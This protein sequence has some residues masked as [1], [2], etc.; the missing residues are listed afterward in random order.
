MVLK[1]STRPLSHVEQ[2]LYLYLESMDKNT[3]KVSEIDI[4]KVGIT[5]SYLYVLVDRL[6]KKGW[7]TRVG[8]GVYLRLPASTAMAGKVYLKIRW[9]SR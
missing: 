8:K 6:E 9:R 3:F 7:L 2:R 4:R 5:P 1:L